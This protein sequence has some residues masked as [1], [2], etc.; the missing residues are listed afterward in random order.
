MTRDCR[1]ILHSRST[2][3]AHIRDTYKQYPML[4]QLHLFTELFHKDFS[5]LLR[6]ISHSTVSCVSVLMM[7]LQGSC[8]EFMYFSTPMEQCYGQYQSSSKALA[9]WT[10]LT[11]HLMTSSVY[12]ALDHGYI[13]VRLAPSV[14][15]LAFKIIM[16]SCRQFGSCQ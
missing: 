13:Q 1:W 2:S 14:L 5:L 15:W 3:T 6:T 4:I 12:Y 7:A 9:K 10:L 8:K 16:V 11:S